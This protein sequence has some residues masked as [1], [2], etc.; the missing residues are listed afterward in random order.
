[1]CLSYLFFWDKVSVWRTG[2]HWTQEKSA[3][4]SRYSG[5]KDIP[6]HVAAL[7]FENTWEKGWG[8][9]DGPSR[10]ESEDTW[11]GSGLAV[12]PLPLMLFFSSSFSPPFCI[13]VF[14]PCRRAGLTEIGK[15][16]EVARQS[17]GVC[18]CQLLAKIGIFI[19]YMWELDF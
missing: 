19:R 10:E 3:C 15:V 14:S 13:Q 18:S 9:G 16:W 12:A 17:V 6:S 2:W 7:Y 8:G 5:I 1:M 4:L 11:T